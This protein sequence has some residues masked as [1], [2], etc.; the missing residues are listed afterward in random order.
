MS[1][2]TAT[3]IAFQGGGALGIAHLGAWRVLAERFRIIGV[4]GTSAGSIVAAFCGAGYDPNHAIDLFKAL[5]WPE[6]I[7][8]QNFFTLLRKRDGWKTTENFY[9]WMR[10]HLTINNPNGKSTFAA[11][12]ERTGIYLAITASDLNKAV[13]KDQVVVFDHLLEKDVD[14]AFAVRASI[15]IPIYFAPIPRP[16]RNQLLVDGGL[17]LNL[18]VELLRPLGEQHQCPIIGVRFSQPYAHLDKPDIL[19]VFNRSLDALLAKGNQPLQDYPNYLDVEI[20]IAG[21]NSH[22]FNMSLDSKEELIRRGE[23]AA[24]MALA[25]YDKS[26]AEKQLQQ[27][28]KQH[29]TS[30]PSSSSIVNTHVTLPGSSPKH[31]TTPTRQPSLDEKRDLTN[32]LLRCDSIKDVSTRQ[33]IIN[34][35]PPEISHR[36]NTHDKPYIHVGN[37]I[38]TSTNFVDGLRTLIQHVRSYEGETISMQEVDRYIEIHQL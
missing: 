15:S 30:N 19:Q 35:L 38:N 12:F 28:Y 33:R 14:V 2:R 23:Q 27:V 31:Q 3:C 17:L 6:F 34:D 24:T 22:D 26:I 21:Y 29:K 7:K 9:Q 32:L 37:M 18:P 13:D 4:S 16:D 5:I 8:S 11:L 10:K 20:N 1:E 25:T 36:I